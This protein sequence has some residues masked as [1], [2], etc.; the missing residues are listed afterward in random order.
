MFIHK[1]KLCKEKSFA[2]RFTYKGIRIPD[3]SDKTKKLIIIGILLSAR[4][5]KPAHAWTFACL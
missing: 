5:L 4:I 1:Y 3:I 2:W